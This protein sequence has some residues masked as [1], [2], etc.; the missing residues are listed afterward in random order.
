M[1]NFLDRFTYKN[2]EW[3]RNLSE[4]ERKEYD[5][6]MD[7]ENKNA[8]T[9]LYG[10]AAFGLPGLLGAAE[11]LARLFPQDKYTPDW[12]SNTLYGLNSTEVDLLQSYRNLG[13]KNL[14][15]ELNSNAY[16]NKNKI[17]FPSFLPRSLR[18]Y[19]Q[20]LNI[21]W[22]L[23]ESNASDLNPEN[24][25]NK[26]LTKVT[27][28]VPD[29]GPDIGG[30]YRKNKEL[31]NNPDPILQKI[32][33]VVPK[34]DSSRF[35]NRILPKLIQSVY[36]DPSI[37]PDK[38]DTYTRTYADPKTALLP[39]STAYTDVP[40]R[41]LYRKFREKELDID[42]Q[43]EL[44]NRIDP[45]QGL[46]KSVSSTL[47]GTISDY[48]RTEYAAIRLG[49]ITSPDPE[50]VVS[51]ANLDPSLETK[52]LFTPHAATP[53]I[54]R[55]SDPPGEYKTGE[56][57]GAVE[58]QV[59]AGTRRK[60][61][62]TGDVSFSSNLIEKRGSLSLSVIQAIQKEN[63][64]PITRG[65]GQKALD[66]GLKSLQSHFGLA[67]PGD[68]VD[69]FARN[70]P[71]L[72]QTTSPR[73]V[74]YDKQ[75]Q[76]VS[77]FDGSIKFPERYRRE[78][79]LGRALTNAGYDQSFE[80]LR[81]LN[82]DVNER[83]GQRLTNFNRFRGLLPTLG[84]TFGLIDPDAARHFARSYSLRESNPEKSHSEFKQG[85]TA[86]GVNTAI[87][88]GLGVAGR[89][90]LAKLA[91]K[92][93]NVVAAVTTN[94][95]S[96]ALFGTAGLVSTG[97]GLYGLADAVTEG[98]TGKGL[99]VRGGEAFRQHVSP[100]IIGSNPQQMV[101]QLFP[102]PKSILSNTPNGLAEIRP[103][104]PPINPVQRIQ[105]TASDT[106][107]QI[108]ANI[109]RGYAA[110]D[111][112]FGGVLPGGEPRRGDRRTDGDVYVDKNWG[113]QNPETAARLFREQQQT[114]VSKSNRPQPGTT[115]NLGGSRGSSN[116]GRP[117]ATRPSSG[118]ASGSNTTASTN[119]RPSSK[120][121]RRT[122]Q[123]PRT[124]D[125]KNEFNYWKNRLFGL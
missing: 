114:K 91:E 3:Y 45:N 59:S 6:Y 57:W 107:Q 54:H 60:K 64:L 11:G 104:T 4:K 111:R 120:G 103:W 92:A 76:L 90:L 105:Q 89:R 99:T 106:N 9:A 32:Y 73:Q 29:F 41:D 113:Y 8:E 98:L 115:S 17:D 44:L 67:T 82:Q 84:S 42:G 72:G 37:K 28:P 34:A 33:T 15:P 125:L 121:Q 56:H 94:P 25:L 63:G 86:F 116:T 13:F 74:S 83:A 68:V 40:T 38:F 53:Y 65:Y 16:I 30:F 49:A 47:W 50:V 78:M 51:L 102:T 75:L 97:A 80:G 24:Y 48:P 14:L 27:T 77:N 117:A 22:P 123:N 110:L 19:S 21:N 70:V 112:V 66:E 93:P 39:E 35:A 119:R 100:Y 10:L 95:K 79:D 87:G 26:K 20:D 7:K 46:G 58:G 36:S 18:R 12:G 52:Y 23:V 62:V 69:R 108:R 71:R 122:G 31:L 124:L 2:S 43:I 85:A 5:E 88:T 81:Q 1:S 61:D 109:D 118:S 55:Y 101:E 96:L